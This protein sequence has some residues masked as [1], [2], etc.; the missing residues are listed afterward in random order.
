[1]TKQQ[2]QLRQALL[3]FEARMNDATQG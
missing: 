1:V 3:D 2:E